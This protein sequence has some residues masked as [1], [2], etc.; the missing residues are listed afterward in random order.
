MP[1]AAILG[2]LKLL[3]FFNFTEKVREGKRVLNV[4][5]RGERQLWYTIQSDEFL[6]R[7]FSKILSRKPGCFLDVGV[8]LGQTALKLMRLGFLGPY[9]G[10]EPNPACVDYVTCLFEANG[11]DGFRIIPIGLANRSGLA[12]FYSD[13]TGDSRAATLIAKFRDNTEDHPSY[14]P[15]F[16]LDE[17]YAQLGIKRASIMKIDVEGFEQ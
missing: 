4:P 14:V 16:K 15:V 10:F 2:R 8:N 3:R 17:I 11:L 6:T 12:E 9:V 5:V 1:I 7:T 13:S